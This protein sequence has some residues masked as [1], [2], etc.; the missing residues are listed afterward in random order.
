R[1]LLALRPYQPFA[2][3]WPSGLTSPSRP[4]GP[5][6]LLTLRAPLALLTLR[7]PLAQAALERQRPLCS[8]S[9]TRTSRAGPALRAC[10]RRASGPERG[11]TARSTN[12]FRI[13]RFVV[14]WRGATTNNV[15]TLHRAERKH[16]PDVRSFHRMQSFH[17]V[18]SFRA[19]CRP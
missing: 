18:Q 2:P 17:V 14:F 10:R 16:A 5:P 4:A 1:A 9:R 19:N 11:A 12:P 15:E 8:H 6:A 7:A 13:I 3:C